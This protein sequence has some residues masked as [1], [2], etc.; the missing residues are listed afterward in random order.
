MIN[1][2]FESVREGGGVRTFVYPTHPQA[3]LAVP[4]DRMN[5]PGPAPWERE[6]QAEAESALAAEAERLREQREGLESALAGFAEERRRYLQR[7]EREVVQLSLALARKILQREA[8]FDPLLLAGAVRV[9]LD[10]LAGAARV[11]LFVSPGQVAA[12]R[13]WAAGLDAECRPEVQPDPQL[14]A[15]VCRL[16]AETGQC[17]L[18]LDLQAAELERGVLELLQRRATP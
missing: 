12:W 6:A 7:L 18:S 8:R 4:A 13:K 5:G 15:G 2:S 10:Q 17:D 14:E 11:E 3:P 9:A 16:R 1:S